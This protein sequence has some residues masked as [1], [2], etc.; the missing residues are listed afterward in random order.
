MYEVGDRVLVKEWDDM[1]SEYGV[2]KSGNIKTELSF[3]PAMRECCGNIMTVSC[4]DED[5]T[6]RLKDTGFWFSNDMIE[7]AVQE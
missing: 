7:G 2:Y 1:A 3:T 4:V 6:Y 5:E